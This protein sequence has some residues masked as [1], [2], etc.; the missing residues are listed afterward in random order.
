MQGSLAGRRGADTGVERPAQTRADPTGAAYPRD[1]GEHARSGR[2]QFQEVLCLA[3]ARHAFDTPP[4]VVYELCRVRGAKYS[5]EF[6][7]NA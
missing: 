5:V 1:A 3:Y 7:K 4:C 2:G 6:L